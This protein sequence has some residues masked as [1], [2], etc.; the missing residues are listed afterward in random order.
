MP[1]D[2]FIDTL[3]RRF[4][5]PKDRPFDRRWETPDIYIDNKKHT[6]ES[7]PGFT[8]VAATHSRKALGS[9]QIH[10]HFNNAH[11]FVLHNPIIND[12]T[13]HTISTGRAGTILLPGHQWK[14]NTICLNSVRTHRAV[15]DAGCCYGLW[16]SLPSSL[17][18]PKNEIKCQEPARELAVQ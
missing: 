11:H 3:L 4:R 15:Y 9:Q 6:G 5:C 17:V 16:C 13:I 8:V 10:G 7:K 14:C 18:S 1:I 2:S 12:I